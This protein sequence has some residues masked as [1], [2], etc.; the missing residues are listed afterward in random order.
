MVN[1]SD[2]PWRLTIRP[3]MR[4]C[5]PRTCGNATCQARRTGSS[6][7]NGLICEPVTSFRTGFKAAAPP[8]RRGAP[9]WDPTLRAALR[10]VLAHP[11]APRATTKARFARTILTNLVLP[12]SPQRASRRSV[13]A[14]RVSAGD[15]SP[16]VAVAVR[17]P[18]PW[19]GSCRGRTVNYHL[20]QQS[21]RDSSWRQK[22]SHQASP[23]DLSVL[24]GSPRCGAFAEHE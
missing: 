16:A 10:A 22:P 7:V 21:K 6:G 8:R 3:A 18:V 12:G 14:A 9:R 17:D 24:L 5:E 1:G 20:V 11:P 13:A 19:R 2:L 15:D 23:H 4:T